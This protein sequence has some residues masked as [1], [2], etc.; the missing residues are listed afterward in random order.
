MPLFLPFEI[1]KAFL[2]EELTQNDYKVIL[3]FEMVSDDLEIHPVNTI[4]T[5]KLRPGKANTNAGNRRVY[6]R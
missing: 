3:N 6:R 4:R 1:A 2:L 5:P